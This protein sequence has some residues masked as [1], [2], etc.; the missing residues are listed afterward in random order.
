MK[1]VLCFGDCN[2]DIIIPINEIPV[3]GGCTFA[4]EMSI[5]MGGSVYNTAS[6]M[7]RLGI[8]PIV[9]SQL[10]TDFFGNLL[11]QH[12]EE[13][14]MITDHIKRTD[15]YP[16]GVT[17]GL[18]SPNGEKRW[19]SVR[20]RA[21]DTYIKEYDPSLVKNKTILFISGV[22]L[23]EGKEGRDTGIRLAHHVKGQ[24]GRVILD[25]NVRVPV[26]EIDEDIRSVFER[27]LP[28]TDVL[29]P[30]EKE[31]ELLGNNQDMREAVRSILSKGVSSVWVKLGDKGCAHFT[32]ESSLDFAA[33][34]VEA[35]D[36]SGAGDS[37]SA[38]VI[39]GIINGFSPLQIGTFANL[40]AGHTVSKLGT[41]GA[42]PDTVEVAKMIKK[43]KGE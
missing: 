31:L 36:T 38:A 28:Y 18:L 26:W 22:G 21:A 41:T 15:Q 35:V 4:S 14:D 5:N 27:I 8:T 23:I 2:V 30:N 19:I 13:Q 29:I 16:T 40:F 25:P 42:L 10:G 9:I 24:G 20:G 6:A 11:W 43:I 17:V 7:K 3:E 12:L 37:F 39:Y 34:E 1:S 33:I 32:S